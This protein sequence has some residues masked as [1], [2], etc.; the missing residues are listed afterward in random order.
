MWRSSE[1]RPRAVRRSQAA[2]SWVSRG[3][4]ARLAPARRASTSPHGSF[5]GRPLS[6]RH[7]FLSVRCRALQGHLLLESS[8]TVGQFPCR[9]VSSRCLSF[10]F[11]SSVS[12]SVLS[13]PRLPQLGPRALTAASPFHHSTI[14]PNLDKGHF[15]SVDSCF[16]QFIASNVTSKSRSHRTVSPVRSVTPFIGYQSSCLL[17]SYWSKAVT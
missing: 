4:F 14:F 10:F 11:F 15:Y 8:T 9:S 2:G 6:E 7:S 13:L 16:R 12:L 1:V 3:F 17:L 5:L